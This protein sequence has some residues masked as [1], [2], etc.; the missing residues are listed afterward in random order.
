MAGHQ[1]SEPYRPGD[2]RVITEHRRDFDAKISHS[3]KGGERG[4]EREKRRDKGG[5]QLGAAKEAAA[6]EGAIAGKEQRESS[7]PL[8]GPSDG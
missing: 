3:R 1:L 4:R 2:A 6:F 8:S 5:Q 7:T